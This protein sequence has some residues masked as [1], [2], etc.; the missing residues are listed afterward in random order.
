M[1]FRSVLVGV[2]IAFALVIGAFLV[3]RARPKAETE[4]PSPEYIRASGKCA[5]CHLRLQYSVLFPN[6]TVLGLIGLWQ[7]RSLVGACCPNGESR[8]FPPLRGEGA[9]Q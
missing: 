3:N 6:L 2:V 4:Q 5:E 9:L 8:I 1:S 7:L